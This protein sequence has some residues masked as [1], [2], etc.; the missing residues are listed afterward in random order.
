MATKKE[1]ELEILKQEIERLKQ[2][3]ERL[4][5]QAST[6]EKNPLE[7]MK[8][9]TIIKLLDETEEVVKKAF[10]IVEGMLIGAIEGVKKNIK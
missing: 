10:S 3:I 7:A 5:M 8:K 4:K 9:E 1:Q 2:E 6:N